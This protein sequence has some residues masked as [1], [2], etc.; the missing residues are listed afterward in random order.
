[1]ITSLGA[2]LSVVSDGVV[3]PY[4]IQVWAVNVVSVVVAIAAS[5]GVITVS[6]VVDG[7]VSPW[8][9]ASPTGIARRM[10]PITTDVWR[11]LSEPFL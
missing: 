3:P 5:V 1:M 2:F 4:Q 8:A 9:R 7:A 11:K 6:V 10:S